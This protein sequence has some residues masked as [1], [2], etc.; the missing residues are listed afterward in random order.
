MK[1]ELSEVIR[2]HRLSVAVVALLQ[3]KLPALAQWLHAAAVEL[4]I[5]AI[6]ESCNELQ[7]QLTNS[8][9][10]PKNQ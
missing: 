5:V 8:Q 9:P 2:G 10:T 6:R 4:E 1:L 3:A 7:A